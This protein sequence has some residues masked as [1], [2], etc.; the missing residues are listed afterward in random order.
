MFHCASWKEVEA[1]KC[2]LKLTPEPICQHVEAFFNHMHMCKA[3]LCLFVSQSKKITQT[4]DLD[5]F[6]THAHDNHN[7]HLKRTKAALT[8]PV[9]LDYQ[10]SNLKYL[11]DSKITVSHTHTHTPIHITHTQFLQRYMCSLLPQETA[12]CRSNKNT[13]F[14]L[15]A[16][17]AVIPK[18]SVTG[19]LHLHH[20]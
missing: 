4:C 2:C 17:V 10:E 6:M 11:L 14:T 18:G 20:F 3:R 12:H 5:G 8:F 13:A 16:T 7:G 15:T 9:I 19:H 1:Q